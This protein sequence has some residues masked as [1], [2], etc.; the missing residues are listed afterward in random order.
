MNP[1]LRSHSSHIPRSRGRRPLHQPFPFP[2]TRERNA[3]LSCRL[4]KKGL[5]TSRTFGPGST[6]QCRRAFE[7]AGRQKTN[8]SANENVNQRNL[9][10]AAGA[11]GRGRERGMEGGARAGKRLPFKSPRILPATNTGCKSPVPFNDQLSVGASL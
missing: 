10:K 6:S 2:V 5:L 4:L 9:V 7:R 3:A 8:V 11:L 1:K